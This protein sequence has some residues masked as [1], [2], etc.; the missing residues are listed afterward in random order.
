M[1][2]YC[3][4]IF[5]NNN[6]IIFCIIFSISCYLPLYIENDL[7]EESKHLLLLKR[8]FTQYI[9]IY[10]LHSAFI[11]ERALSILSRFFIFNILKFYFCFYLNVN[12]F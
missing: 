10:L 2:L 7:K 6:E 4:K 11:K 3:I 1:H 12:L 8:I 9:C 5:F